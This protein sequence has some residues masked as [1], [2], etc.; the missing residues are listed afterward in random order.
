MLQTMM[1]IDEALKITKVIYHAKDLPVA[2]PE[3]HLYSEIAD[4]LSLYKEKEK[5]STNQLSKKLNIP[6]TTVISILNKKQYPKSVKIALALMVYFDIDLELFGYDLI[7]KHSNKYPNQHSIKDIYK[8]FNKGLK[9]NIM[10]RV[11]IYK[12][13]KEFAKKCFINHNSLYKFIYESKISIK[14]SA[15]ISIYIKKNFKRII[16]DGLVHPQ[17][18]NP[19]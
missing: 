6:K 4:R 19:F 3:L 18:F 1:I 13:T 15:N 14:T 2:T 7:K 9:R 8:F 11:P 5:L 16:Y 12:N 17:R 10:Y